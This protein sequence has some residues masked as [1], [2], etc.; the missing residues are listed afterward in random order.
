MSVMFILP[1]VP[2]FYF[3]FLVLL[4]CYLLKIVLFNVVTWG[5]FLGKAL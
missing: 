1:T 2:F 5:F 3:T 4:F